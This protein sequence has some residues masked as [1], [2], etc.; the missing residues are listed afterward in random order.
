[1]THVSILARLWGRALPV[2]RRIGT[3]ITSFQSSPGF[4][5][6]RYNA[7]PWD[8]CI[9]DTFQSSPGFGAGRYNGE[10]QFMESGWKFQS[11]PG[12]G[13]G[14]YIK[15]VDIIVKFTVS[16]LARLWGRALRSA[17]YDIRRRS[18]C[19][20]PRPALG[21]GATLL[22]DMG[23][24]SEEGFNPRPALGPGATRN[25]PLWM[26]PSAVSILARLWGRAL[27]INNHLNSV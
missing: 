23:W 16:I 20:N 2:K 10:W 27:P 14:R 11:S 18:S 12:F 5:A 8:E 9:A 21:P 24:L 13:A 19:F 17:I 7:K 25:P 6:G 15:T 4:G 3:K 1:M 26:P 22:Y